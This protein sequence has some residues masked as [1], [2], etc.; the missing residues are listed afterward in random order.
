MLMWQRGLGEDLF[1][2]GDI[3]VDSLAQE[4]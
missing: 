2:A 4:H 1:W 3:D